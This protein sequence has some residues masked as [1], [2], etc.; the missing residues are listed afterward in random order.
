MQSDSLPFADS[1]AAVGS[2]V[3]LHLEEYPTNSQ[4]ALV[5]QVLS[6]FPYNAGL[7]M[8]SS[9]LSRSLYGRHVFTTFLDPV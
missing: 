3:A 5:S 7:Q 2:W 9:L 6:D 1:C 4:D 8:G